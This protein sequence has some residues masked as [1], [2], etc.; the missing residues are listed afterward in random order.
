MG[1]LLIIEPYHSA[2]R[3]AIHEQYVINMAIAGESI[4][5]I[6]IS[7]IILIITVAHSQL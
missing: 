3:K 2:C 7:S 1:K 4:T 6:I 5:V